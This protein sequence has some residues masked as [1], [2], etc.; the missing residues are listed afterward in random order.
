[1]DFSVHRSEKGFVVRGKLIQGGVPRSFLAPVP[2]YA[3]EGGHS[4]E[5][6]V[7]VASGPETKFQF[8]TP[9]A[10]GKILIDPR[11]TL[12]CSTE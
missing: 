3:N 7:V 10:P 11:M 5:L 12:L 8:T 4:V 9:A 1:V 6:G 2:L